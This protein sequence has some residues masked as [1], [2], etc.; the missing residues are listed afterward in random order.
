MVSSGCFSRSQQT[1][2]ICDST[3]IVMMLEDE[4]AFT[5]V[6]KWVKKKGLANIWRELLAKIQSSIA[7]IND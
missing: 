5:Y 3:S 2:H 1:K 6:D 4:L 7:S